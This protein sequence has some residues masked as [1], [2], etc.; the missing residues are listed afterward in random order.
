MQHAHLPHKIQIYQ[1]I[2]IAHRNPVS[3]SISIINLHD[4]LKPSE[5]HHFLHNRWAMKIYDAYGF[6]VCDEHV[7]WAQN[8][9]ESR[10]SRESFYSD[11][12][13]RSHNPGSR[14][15]PNSQTQIIKM[16]KSSPHSSPDRHFKHDKNVE[17]KS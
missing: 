6:Y 11:H 16:R 15:N 10:L 13:V 5:G 17:G 3:I 9:S 4:R 1:K 8:T 2:F 12:R 14:N 7:A